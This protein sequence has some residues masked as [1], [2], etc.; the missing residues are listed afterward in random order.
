MKWTNVT[1]DI[2]IESIDFISA[3][4]TAAPFLVAITTE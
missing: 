3:M 2:Q 4:G 1:P